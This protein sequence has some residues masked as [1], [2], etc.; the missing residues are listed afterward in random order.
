MWL[1]W[2]CNPEYCISGSLERGGT[3]ADNTSSLH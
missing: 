1:T 2:A 3:V